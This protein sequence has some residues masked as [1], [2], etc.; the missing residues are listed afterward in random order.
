MY[1]KPGCIDADRFEKMKAARDLFMWF[2]DNVT[3]P[4]CIEN[5]RPLK[6]AN[7]PPRS[8]VVCPSDFGHPYTKR[9]YLWLRGLPP[10]VPT[11][12]VPGRMVNWNGRTVERWS[13]QTDSGQNKLPPSADR[14]ALRSETYAGIAQAMAEQWG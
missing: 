12:R 9:T 3:V 13:N 11:A 14:W 8:Q 1:P 6:I 5:P 2:W 10:L 4:L 7:L